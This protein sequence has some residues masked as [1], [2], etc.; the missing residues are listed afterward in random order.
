[1]LQLDGQIGQFLGMGGIVAGH[2]LHQRQQLV[3]GGV[4][5][6]AVAAA[7]TAA[8]AVMAVLMIVAAGTLVGVVMVCAVI[9]EMIV[10]VGMGMVMGMSVG[11]LM[12]MG[13]TVMGMLVRM[14][15]LVVML[16]AM[17]ADMIVMD[18]H[19]KI[20]FCHFLS[21]IPVDP[22][23][24]KTFISHKISPLRACGSGKNGV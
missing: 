6:V 2:V 10:G 4:L 5:A 20:S 3:H 11:V 21:I 13:M 7:A 14:S 18:M 16:V 24:V 17:T 9:V 22:M 1:M 8:V 15:V 12:G 23:D 19:G